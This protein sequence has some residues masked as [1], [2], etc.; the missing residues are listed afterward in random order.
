MKENLNDV[1]FL[2]LVRLDSVQRLENLLVVT[3]VLLKH[4]DTNVTI[5]ESAPYNN[6]I[7]QKLLNRK[8]AYKFVEDR[9]N[10]LYKT[11]YYNEIAQTVK[12]PC[13]AIWDTDIV[14]DRKAIIETVSRLR[15]GAD[16]AFPYSGVCYDIPEIIRALYLKNNDI[17]ILNRNRDKMKLLYEKQLVGGAVFVKTAKYLETGGDNETIYGWGNDDFV[18]YENWKAHNFSIYRTQNPLFHLC[19]PRGENSRYRTS[20]HNKISGAELWKIKSSSLKDF[21][22]E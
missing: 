14:I 19:H 6:G 5:W 10:V 12:T 1:T 21:D 18:R 3:D 22:N 7:L 17:R 8:I 13:M 20:F 2:F 4:F 15:N 9:D 11:R 16:A